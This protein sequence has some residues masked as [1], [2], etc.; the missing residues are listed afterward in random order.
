MDSINTD[1][2]VILPVYNCYPAFVKGVGDLKKK[3]ADLNLNY[4]LLVVNDGS[5]ISFKEINDE[6]L[7]R[8]C[9][10]IAYNQNRGKGYAVKKGVEAANGKIIMYMDGDLPFEPDVIRSAATIFFTTNADVVIGDRTN[11]LSLVKSGTDFRKFGSNIVSKFANF[12]LIKNIPDTQCGFK[13]FRRDVAKKIFSKQTINGYSFDIEILYLAQQYNY[14]IS[15][16]PVIVNKQFNSNVKL[17]WHGLQMILN[18]VKIRLN[19]R[20]Y[21]IID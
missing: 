7:V 13:A 3:L 18:I 12:F 9:K 5:E 8:D 17:I 20:S 1:I 11:N 6:A 10:L 19:K 21:T 15:S 14:N 4:E 2:S 16:V